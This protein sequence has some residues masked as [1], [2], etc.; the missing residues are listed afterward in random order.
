MTL[1]H[2]KKKELKEGPECSLLG[3]VEMHCNNFG[4]VLGLGLLR[5]STRVRIRVNL[6]LA[7][8][9]G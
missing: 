8:V 4:L 2:M 9:M 3:A 6:R 7:V 1:H 5:V